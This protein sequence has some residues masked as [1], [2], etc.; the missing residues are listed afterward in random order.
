[1]SKFECHPAGALAKLQFPLILQQVAKYCIGE[2][3]RALTHALQPKTEARA[4]EQELNKVDEM[5]RMLQADD[6]LP[7]NYLP[8]ILRLLA[9]IKAGTPFLTAEELFTLL[10]WMRTLH[11]VL[12][13]FDKNKEKYPSLAE[14]YG[15]K[16]HDLKL[17]K[18]IE[19]VINDEGQVRP[20]AS[21][22]LVKLRHQMA[23]VSANL[24]N[25]MQIILREAKAQGWT[26]EREL[27]VRNQRLVIPIKADF[28]GRLK[29]LIHDLSGSGQTVYIEPLAAVPLNNEL[30]ELSLREENEIRR[31]LT[32]LT[33]NIRP[34]VDALLP[35]A[36][37][38]SEIDSLRARAQFAIHTGS[39][40]PNIDPRGRD[41]VIHEAKH[42]LLILEKGSD[43]V[44]PLSLKLDSVRRILVVSGPNA[45]GKSVALQ[46][47]GL[48]QAM[49]QS[50]LLIPAD[51]TT[52]LPVIQRLFVD[53]GDDQSLQNDLSTYSS[54][55]TLMRS[56][57]ERYGAHSM[58][59]LDE[60]GAGT[61]PQLGGAIAEALLEE[62]ANRRGFGM[63]NT[64]YSN[65]KELAER[66]PA[67]SNGAM[68][69]DLRTIS[70]LYRLEQG[71]PGSS[72]AFEIA[73]RVGI[74]APVI[75]SA[76]NKTGEVRSQSESLLQRLKEQ[77]E[78][79]EK[80]EKELDA[81]KRELTE[82]SRQLEHQEKEIRERK[83]AAIRKARESVEK[84]MA[85]AQKRIDDTIDE[86]RSNQAEK[87]STLRLRK[88]LDAALHGSMDESLSLEPS[89]SE[90]NEMS[91]YKDSSS[92]Q[93]SEGDSVRILST[94]AIG[95]VASVGKKK[96]VIEVGDF[97]MTVPIEDLVKVDHVS[98]HPSGN[99]SKNMNVREFIGVERSSQA[100][101]KI[102]LR[103]FRVEDAIKAID[104]FMDQLLMAG[105]NEAAILHG[106]GTGALRSALR[107]HVKFNYP[108]I[109]NI[110]D[111][112]DNQGGNG[113]TILK[114]QYAHNS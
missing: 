39:T 35:S 10:R 94:Q 31:L 25:S 82:K 54:H 38:L 65:L 21:P 107:Q 19:T 95:L 81:L 93:I 98:V 106:K 101:D 3:G 14:L 86:I 33:D 68:M 7:L 103:G 78:K 64:H 75:R 67:L 112:P 34:Q 89:E 76:Q 72:F 114:M 48:M 45:G 99:G 41:L 90:L 70:P 46:T 73:A 104:E 18:Q 9:S 1:M 85:S 56:V 83:A 77:Y 79:T 62:F 88:Q 17:I 6:R 13:F 109:Q 100:V 16:K 74:P 51:P 8:P 61:D 27:T 24:R 36:H 37:Y 26:D 69:F 23:E 30:K 60:F 80:K 113:V 53:I 105:L 57:C 15:G 28:K 29:G 110:S 102:D 50:G 55:L 11:A 59:L 87:N 49:A 92:T 44:V 58:L 47:V 97:R 63:I 52:T 12:H 2:E 111:A 40:K 91:E 84:L 32:E 20:D 43:K 71:L 96:H 22:T 4:I 42:P 108:Q 66:L 5:R